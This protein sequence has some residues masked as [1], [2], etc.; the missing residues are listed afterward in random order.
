QVA[1]VVSRAFTKRGMKL[2]TGVKITSVTPS[3]NSVELQ[4]DNAKGE[5]EKLTVDRV[6]VS[7]G[8]R[9]LSENMG[10]DEA[11]VKVN[12]S[13]F[14]VGDGYMRTNVEGVFAVGDVVPTPQLAHVAFAESIVVIKTI[15][16]ERV[17]PVDYDK[18][19]W[20]IYCHPEV[21]F[22]GLTE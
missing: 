7:I 19:P 13:G 18:V 2:Q 4:Y 10:F 21:G 17:Q 12:E 15:H 6:V 3:S 8:R 14:V 16:N 20:G 5:P 9:P 22:C 1:Q 11:G